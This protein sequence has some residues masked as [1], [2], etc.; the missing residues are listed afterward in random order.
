M[1]SPTK[2]L[3]FNYFA[4]KFWFNGKGILVPVLLPLAVCIVGGSYYL[5]NPYLQ[6]PDKGPVANAGFGGLILFAAGVLI[7]LYGVYLF[8]ASRFFG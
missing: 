7:I 2:E 8:I 4:K 5:L 6:I 1:D 3:L